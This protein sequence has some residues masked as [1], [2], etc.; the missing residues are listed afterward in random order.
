MAHTGGIV[1]RCWVPV[2]AVR[3]TATLGLPGGLGTRHRHVDAAALRSTW[4]FV[5][6]GGV[7]FVRCRRLVAT[8]LGGCAD[9]VAN[10]GHG[11]GLI[12]ALYRAAVYIHWPDLEIAANGCLYVQ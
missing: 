5:R 12:E 8:P 9:V 1:A 3:R 2:A 4:Q 6:A 10:E 11:G 7:W